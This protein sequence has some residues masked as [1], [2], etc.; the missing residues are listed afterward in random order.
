MAPPTAGLADEQR[1]ACADLLGRTNEKPALMEAASA[2]GF[3]R[4]STRRPVGEAD[5]MT[6][7]LAFTFRS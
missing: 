7:L 2:N 1:P 4:G 6:V 3:S 5:Y